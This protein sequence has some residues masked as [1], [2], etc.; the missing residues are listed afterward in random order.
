MVQAEM[1]S[2]Q[3]GLCHSP[4]WLFGNHRPFLQLSICPQGRSKTITVLLVGNPENE[5]AVSKNYFSS[6]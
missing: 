6:G 2:A 1:M 5:H 4:A 3:Y